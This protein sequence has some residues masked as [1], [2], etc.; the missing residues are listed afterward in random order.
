MYSDSL[1]LSDNCDFACLMPFLSSAV[2]FSIFLSVVAIF[3][4]ALQLRSGLHVNPGGVSKQCYKRAY[5]MRDHYLLLY[6]KIKM[7]E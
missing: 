5:T 6:V 7:Y 1:T 4:S 2:D 3:I